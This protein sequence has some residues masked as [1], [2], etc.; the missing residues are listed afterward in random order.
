METPGGMLNAVGLQNPGVD[1]F[2]KHH[3]PF[4]TSHGIPLIAQ[5]V[6]KSMEEYLDVVPKLCVPGVHAIELNVSCPNVKKGCSFSV[7]PDSLET[8]VREVKRVCK[9]PLIVKLSP[10]VTSITTS[11]LAAERGGADAI[12][13]I[14]TIAG[15]AVDIDTRKPILGNRMGGLSG[16]C[17]KPVALKMVWDVYNAV[18]IP[19]IGCGG[20]TNYRDVIEF[21]LCGATLVQVGTLNMTDPMATRQI[22][23]DLESW[24]VAKNIKNLNEIVGGLQ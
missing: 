7:D 8:L 2:I 21:I 23:D 19:I 6:G 12:S 9:L 20:I 4:M 18:K 15:M 1:A 3:L 13:L 5:A 24:C 14:N 16:P 17:V 10:N 22:I 11:A